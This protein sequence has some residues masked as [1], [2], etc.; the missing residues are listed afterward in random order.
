M[1]SVWIINIIVFN[2]VCLQFD[3]YVDSA[4]ILVD[5]LALID[6]II[7]LV[8]VALINLN[9]DIRLNRIS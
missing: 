1:A 8:K 7:I 4:H 9:L 3:R 2:V 5:L 6:A